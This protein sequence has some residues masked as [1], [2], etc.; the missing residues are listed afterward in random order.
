MSGTAPVPISATTAANTKTNE[1]FTNITDHVNSLT[2]A[3]SALGTAPTGT[4]VMA[5]N[6]VSLPS[7][8]AGAAV[9]PKSLTGSITTTGTSVKASAGNLYGVFAIN[10]AVKGLN[11][12]ASMFSG[13]TA[14]GAPN[15]FGLTAPTG[16]ALGV[17]ASLCRSHTFC[18]FRIF[19]IDLDEKFNQT[20]HS[21]YQPWQRGPWIGFNLDLGG[22][23]DCRKIA[24]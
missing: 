5:V 18:P 3:L 6:N 12:N 20:T 8:A 23:I 16:N 21:Q 19:R 17:N 7:T 1:F 22:Q 2:A 14:L 9:S 15:T 10:G 24:T 13:T 4:Q 11:I